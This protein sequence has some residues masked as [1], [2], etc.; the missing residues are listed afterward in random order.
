MHAESHR[1]LAQSSPLLR[2]ALFATAIAHQLPVDVLVQRAL[3][4]ELPGAAP[5]LVAK[6]DAAVVDLP[7][8]VLLQALEESPRRPLGLPADATEEQRAAGAA[9]HLQAA[10]AGLAEGWPAPESHAPAPASVAVDVGDEGPPS[11]EPAP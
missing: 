8:A 2:P 11:T 7:G 9:E 1:L 4:R 3:G 5:E 6:V 10:L